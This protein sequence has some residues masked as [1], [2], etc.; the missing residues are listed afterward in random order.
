MFI[1]VIESKQPY[2][3]GFMCSNTCSSAGGD[4]LGEHVI[5]ETEDLA[6]GP[7]PQGV[8]LK[9]NSLS[10]LTLIPVPCLAPC[11]KLQA[12]STSDQPIPETI[13]SLPCL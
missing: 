10:L 11:E 5:S 3:H 8:G 2:S 1:I 4:V 7:R 12:L 9:G 6:N 13:P